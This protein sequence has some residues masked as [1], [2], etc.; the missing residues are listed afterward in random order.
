MKKRVSMV[1][2]AAMAASLA[3]SVATPAMAEGENLTVFNSK[4]EIQ[5]QFEEVA[6]TYSE[7]AGVAM[8]VYY[9]NDT[10]AAHMGSRY[11][12]DDPYV[13]SMVDAKDVYSLGPEHAIDLSDQEWV[14]NTPYAISVDDK[15]LGFPVCVEARGVIYNADAIE[16]ITG[17]EFVPADYATL[18]AFKGLLDTL[19]EGGMAAPVGILKEDWSIGAHFLAQ[20][21][22]QQED[23]EAFVQSLYEGSADLINNEKFNALMDTFD[24]LMEYNYAKDSAIAAERE[25]TS[26]KLAEGEIAFM[27]GGNWDWSVINQYDYS[28]NMGI[29]PVPQNLDDGAN[30]KLTGGGSKYFY[31][32]SAESITD[33]QRQAAKDFL[34]WMVSDEAGQ[35]FLVDSCAL[36]PAFTNIS[37]EV[38]DPLGAS[39]KEYADAGNLIPNYDYLPDDHYSICGASFQKYLAGQIDREG[40]A[41]ELEAYWSST[42]PVEH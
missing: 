32:D 34:N 12:A 31:I 38:A 30:T 23:P 5:T 22:E 6:S 7:S 35:S 40:F 28:E 4:M 37:L 42:T 13:M 21:Y 20:V 2:A 16:A 25:V 10:V 14:A 8:E 15:V 1:M 27:F 33:E 26:Q 19:V 39:V 11:A 41:G 36:V 29:M 17:E 18:D 9:S 3:A 24:V